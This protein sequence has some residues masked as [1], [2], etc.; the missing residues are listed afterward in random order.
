[1]AQYMVLFGAAVEVIGVIPYL[2][3]TLHGVTKPNQVTWLL[4]S[5]A[6]LIAA[7]AAF[8]DG[9][10]WPVIPVLLAGLTPL[11]VFVASFAHSTAMWKLGTVDYI[12]GALSVIAL[13]IWKVTHRPDI[14]IFFSIVSDALATLPTLRKSWLYPETETPSAYLTT[15]IGALTGL[16]ASQTWSV[17]ECAFLIYLVITFT[18]LPGIIYFQRLS[19]PIRGDRAF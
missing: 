13:V 6:P 9:V 11:V 5:M 1:M 2:R 19:P 3:D 4:W 16:L 8:S 15:L 10:G 17:S 7:T 14:A 18:I 12:C